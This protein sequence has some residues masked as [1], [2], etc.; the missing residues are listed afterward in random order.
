MNI[1][2]WGCGDHFAICSLRRSPFAIIRMFFFPLYINTRLWHSLLY[3]LY[4]CLHSL[5]LCKE[6]HGSGPYTLEG[7]P[8]RTPLEKLFRQHDQGTVEAAG[9][10]VSNCVMGNKNKE[11]LFRISR[12]SFIGAKCIRYITAQSEALRNDV[13]GSTNK[14][15]ILSNERVKN[16]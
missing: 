3:S 4:T 7:L 13:T 12:R 16:T 10:T 14:I 11:S 15:E 1:I 6:G 9:K 5:I 8:P 2:I